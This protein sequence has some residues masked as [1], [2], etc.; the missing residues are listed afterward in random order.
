VK[1]WW[2]RNNNAAVAGTTAAQPQQLN[3]SNNL[4]KAVD[5]AVRYGRVWSATNYAQLILH[6][7]PQAGATDSS[8]SS[9]NTNT[10][11]SSCSSN[12]KT[13]NS[14]A[15]NSSG[16]SGAQQEVAEYAAALQH[17]GV[18]TVANGFLFCWMRDGSADKH[19]H[20]HTNNSSNSSSSSNVSVSVQEEVAELWQQTALLPCALPLRDSSST[21]SSCAAATARNGCGTNDSA[22]LQRL[23]SM[24]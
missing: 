2:L 12:A 5:I 22:L 24:H 20:H 1:G 21:H 15:S 6:P 17:A 7:W 10:S 8:S 13:S 18:Q 23:C 16:S 11:G 19:K 4:N 3:N 14:S 9:S